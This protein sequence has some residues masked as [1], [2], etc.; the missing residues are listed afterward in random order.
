MAKVEKAFWDI[1]IPVCEVEVNEKNKIVVKQVSKNDVDYIDVRKS[2]LDK[3]GNWKH[4][5]GIAI[6]MEHA[7]DIADIIKGASKEKL[8]F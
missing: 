7:G 1:E 2:F 8:P 3:E 6:P 5:K 4:G